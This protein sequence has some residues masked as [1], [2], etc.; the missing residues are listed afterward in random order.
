MADLTELRSQ[1]DALDA[2]LFDLFTQR[3]A[4]A[5]TIGAYKREQGLRVFD[6]A[7]ERQKVAAA[8]QAV[9]EDLSTY[10]QVFMEVLM[11]AS[12]ARQ[13]VRDVFDNDLVQHIAKAQEHTPDL[14]PQQAFV[15]CQGI[16]GAFSQLAAER[17]FKHPTL[18]YFDTFEAVF[19]AVEQDFCEYGILPIENST[20]GSVNQVYDLMMKHNFHIIRTTRLKIDHCVLAKPGVSLDDITEI[21]SHEQALNQCSEFLSEHPSIKVH[22]CENTAVA[23][24]RVAESTS[25][26]VAALSSH[27]CA[28]LYDLVVLKSSVQNSDANYTRFAVISKDLKIFPGAHRTSLM[29]VVPHRPGS[30]YKV[31]A[32]FYALDINLIKLESRPLPNRD[33]EF[34]FYFDIDCP[35]VA[36]EFTTLMGTLGSLTEELRYL[37]SYSEVV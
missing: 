24:Q 18:S 14:F 36:Q 35:V 5:D 20:A 8:A 22:V 2:Q 17:F 9:P 27:N 1:I 19:K 29:V 34:M 12:R 16:E 32:K 30:L 25:T 15:A 11:E 37:G 28:S 33:F 31:L 10:G 4:L 26:T 23:A 6:P 7:R 21:Y 13:S 3:A